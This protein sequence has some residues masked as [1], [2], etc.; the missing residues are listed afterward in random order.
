VQV[1]PEQLQSSPVE[2]KLLTLQAHEKKKKK[3]YFFWYKNNG[4]SA[5][6]Q[7][8]FKKLFLSFYNFIYLVIY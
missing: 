2:T 7:S 8:I 5:P 3:Q 1:F 4:K 6:K